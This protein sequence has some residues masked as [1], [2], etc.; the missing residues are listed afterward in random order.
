MV[1][2]IDAVRS[3][4]E[5]KEKN[6]K[7]IGFSER[8]I[9][10]FSENE[11]TKKNIQII[12]EDESCD[13]YL[14][15]YRNLDFNNF[16]TKLKVSLGNENM[17]NLEL[18]YANYL[19]GTNNFKSTYVIYKVLEK[20]FKKT[21]GRG[22]EYF[23]TKL[24]IKHLHN[25]I[26]HYEYNDIDVMIDD[27]ESINL[28]KVIYDELE[29][30][31]DDETKKYLI[32]IK[33][34]VLI[35][36]VQDQIEDIVLKIEDKKNIYDQGGVSHSPNLAYQL[37]NSYFLLFLHI[38][39]NFIIYDVFNRYKYLTQKVFKGLFTAYLTPDDHFITF[40]SFLLTE[41]ILHIHSNDFK[42]ITERITY[43]KVDNKSINILLNRLNNYIK[44]FFEK[45]MFNK[46]YKNKIITEH[47]N[48]YLFRQNLTNI[49]SNLFI[50]F[51]KLDVDKA[52]F[53]KCKQPLLSFLEIEDFL[54][55]Y[56][57]KEFSNF[58]FLKGDLFEPVE[59]EKIL[60]IA[61]MKSDLFNPTYSNLIQNLPL[62]IEKYYPE[63]KIDNELLIQTAIVRYSSDKGANTNYLDLVNLLKICNPNCKNIL[64]TAFEKS[65]DKKFEPHF[66]QQLLLSDNYNYQSKN[67]F[68]F[69]SNHVSIYKKSAYDFGS[70]KLTDIHFIN[71][72]FIIYKLGIDFNSAELKVFSDLN[73]F[74]KWLLNPINFDYSQFDANWLI[75]LNNTI[76]IDK[77][78]GNVDI[79]NAIEQQLLEK[80]DPLLAKIKY[81]LI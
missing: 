48:N 47:L 76:V 66:Y 65:L 46:A 27:I 30:E 43:L 17:Y 3:Y 64:L 63:F 67:Y 39:K 6:K 68:L 29:F 54:A 78:K 62:S 51:S 21:E 36:R 52:I 28:D 81:E 77:L 8:H 1:S 35:Y 69:Y 72:V 11:G 19:A 45:D 56:N 13:C 61:I 80:F 37:I 60:E 26:H 57:V 70:N 42:N 75:D 58:V 12:N 15:N 32:N 22:V 74:E 73:N 16:L 24:N 9:F 44:S 10:S 49:F 4:K 14:C 71:Y 55:W 20:R 79:I 33:E 31:I 41:A 2:Q 53:E 25:L 40:D 18:A 5:I 38:N 7:T 34:D 50:V 23:L 59:L